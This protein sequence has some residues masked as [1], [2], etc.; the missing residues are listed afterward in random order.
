MADPAP[1]VT[2]SAQVGDTGPMFTVSGSGFTPNSTVHVRIVDDALN[3]LWF[4]QSADASGNLNMQQPINCTPGALHFSANDERPNP[5][6]A[7][8]TLWSNTLSSEHR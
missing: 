3:T 6:D 4:T 1:T 7:T 8:G 2:V 5:N